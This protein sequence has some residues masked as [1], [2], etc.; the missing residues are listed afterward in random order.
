MPSK[1][2]AGLWAIAIISVALFGAFD[3]LPRPIAAQAVIVLPALA[4]AMLGVSAC[5]N[6]RRCGART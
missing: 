1:F 6:Q 4:S 2:Q 3:L 5:Q